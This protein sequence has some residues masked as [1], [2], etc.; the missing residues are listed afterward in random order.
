MTEIQIHNGN[1]NPISSHSN[2][3]TEWRLANM[4]NEKRM[5]NSYQWIEYEL[6]IKRNHAFYGIF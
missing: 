4:K 3:H 5:Y 2:I 6:Q 1:E